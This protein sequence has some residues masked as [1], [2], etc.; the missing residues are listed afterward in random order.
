M[1]MAPTYV[2]RRD[3]PLASSECSGDAPICLL[4]AGLKYRKFNMLCIYYNS[5]ID[6]YYDEYG[7]RLVR[8]RQRRPP[9]Y[10]WKCYKLAADMSLQRAA[11]ELQYRQ[12]NINQASKPLWHIKEQRRQNAHVE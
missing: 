11:T 7:D 12:L 4:H 2:K 10:R 1:A 5:L 9:S 8:G 3:A 6:D